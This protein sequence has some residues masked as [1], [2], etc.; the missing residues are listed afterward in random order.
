[1]KLGE[2]SGSPIMGH[3]Q[4]QTFGFMLGRS[5][6]EPYLVTGSGEAQGSKEGS[7]SRVYGLSNGL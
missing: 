2:G 3:N 5:V 7:P 4:D 6:I 1:M